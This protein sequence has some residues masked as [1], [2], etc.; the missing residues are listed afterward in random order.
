MTTILDV[1]FWFLGVASCGFLAF[2]AWNFKRHLETER[3]RAE[4]R[5]VKPETSWRRTPRLT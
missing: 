5:R 4:R 2:C 3:L 1:F